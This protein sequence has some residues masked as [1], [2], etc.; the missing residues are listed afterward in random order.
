MQEIITLLVTMLM[1]NSF[2]M[3][4]KA[5][6]LCGSCIVLLMMI[7]K[8]CSRLQ[9]PPTYVSEL[10]KDMS[11]LYQYDEIIDDRLE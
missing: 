2:L 11:I 6:F 7:L 9:R 8:C 1:L 5:E 3:Q 4:I 10:Y